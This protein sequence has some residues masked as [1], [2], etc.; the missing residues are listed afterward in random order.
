MKSPTN[1]LTIVQSAIESG[2]VLLTP[3]FS[4]Q[5][6]WLASPIFHKNQE[7]KYNKKSSNDN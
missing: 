6:Y 1:E 2:I 3:I 4:K 5:I 7:K